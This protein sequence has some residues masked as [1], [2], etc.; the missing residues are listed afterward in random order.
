MR[1]THIL[2]MI[3]AAGALALACA[4]N[5][6]PEPSKGPAPACFFSRDWQG[7]K[8][9]DDGKS[10]YIRVGRRQI[11]RLDLASS[12]PDLNYPSAHLVTQLRGDSIC[13]A[14][15]IDLKVSDGSGFAVPCIVRK[16]S[17]LSQAEAA[18]LPK[19]LQP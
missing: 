1:T 6:L 14:L 13:D 8:A 19:A 9:T 2:S 3:G 7:W 5:A 15:D 16:L 17:Q 18:A 10:I 4:P 11:Y 12:C